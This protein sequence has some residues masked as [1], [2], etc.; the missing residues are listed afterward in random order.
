M[1]TENYKILL[2]E[3]K[4]N[5]NKWKDI[6]F[7]WIVFV[8]MAAQWHMGVPGPGTE[9]KLQLQPT[10]QLWQYKIYNPLCWA[11]DQTHSSAVT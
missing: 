4:E 3:V 2:Q 9:S 8:F 10:P 11:G 5:T 1:Y 6:P 7:T